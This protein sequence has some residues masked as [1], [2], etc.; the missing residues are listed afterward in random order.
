MDKSISQES[1]QRSKFT[2]K[3]DDT[4]I[5]QCTN[6]DKAYQWKSRKIG[7]TQIL[8]IISRNPQIKKGGGLS[9][10]RE[11]ENSPTY[12]SHEREAIS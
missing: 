8:E 10:G 5:H 2:Y 7:E 3:G 11:H 1:S 12:V 6:I 4:Q 9:H